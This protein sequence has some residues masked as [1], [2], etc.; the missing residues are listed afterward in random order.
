MCRPEDGK[1]ISTSPTRCSPVDQLR[2]VDGADDEAGEI[3]FAVGVEAGHLGGL[4]AEQRTAVV[5]AGAREPFDDLLGDVGRQAAR[6]EVIEKKQRRRALHEDVVDAVIDEIDA[7]GVVPI[8]HER[9]LQL[10]ADAVGARHQNR[11]AP[12]GGIEPEQP[13]ERADLGQHAGR[14]CRLRQPLDAAHRL[15]AG[16]D[17]DAG[18]L[19]IHVAIAWRLQSANAVSDRSRAQKSS[20]VIS[21]SDN[22]RVREPSAAAQ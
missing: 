16:V 15:V 10:G 9:H 11:I 21:C 6:R 8:G 12:S 7:N 3:V 1:P 4:A 18:S 19:V 20:L 14:E 22:R 2:R 17:V 13:A 5:P